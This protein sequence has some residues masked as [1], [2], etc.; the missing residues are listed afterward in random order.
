MQSSFN[1]PPNAE[2]LYHSL[3]IIEQLYY[4]L[5]NEEQLNA[6]CQS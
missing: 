6:S 5:P 2:Q 4:S 1:T 3:S